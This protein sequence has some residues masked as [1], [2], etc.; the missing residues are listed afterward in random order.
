M[1][2]IIAPSGY[3][4]QSDTLLSL[5]APN[6]RS[7]ESIDPE[8]DSIHYFNKHIVP[9]HGLHNLNVHNCASFMKDLEMNWERLIPETKDKV[10]DILVLILE[11]GDYDLKNA[12]I[13]KLKLKKTEL[14]APIVKPTPP[15]VEVPV[16]KDKNNNVF[17]III[18][19][20]IL[21]IVFLLV[22]KK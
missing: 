15:S 3:I 5:D 20:L 19:I 10:I 16:K 11:S 12:L 22:T 9:R 14:V 17:Y 13:N 1:N 7:R 21:C 18:V 8:L 6:T 4:D 2:K